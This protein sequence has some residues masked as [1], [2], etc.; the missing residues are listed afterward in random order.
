MGKERTWP[1]IEQVG[2]KPRLMQVVFK[3]RRAGN[4]EA[5]IRI[6]LRSSLTDVKLQ[7]GSDM[8]EVG[9]GTH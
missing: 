5:T 8:L 2:R 3:V 6:E 7:H 9:Q 4:R 1:R